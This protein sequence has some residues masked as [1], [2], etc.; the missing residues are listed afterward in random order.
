MAEQKRI[1]GFWGGGPIRA[2]LPKLQLPDFQ[3][4]AFFI[5]ILKKLK[6]YIACISPF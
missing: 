4:H 5:E 1:F 2:F 6:S 3:N